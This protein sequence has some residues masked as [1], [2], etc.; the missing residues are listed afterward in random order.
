MIGKKLRIKL[1]LMCISGGAF[2]QQDPMYTQYMFNTLAVNPAYAGSRNVLS[3]TGLYRSQWVGMQGA[4]ETQTLSFD[5]SLPN[6]KVGLGFQVFNDKIGITQT[7]GA[8]ASYAFRIRMEESTLAFGIQGG[9]SNFKANYTSV[10]TNQGTPGGND[11][12]F[13]EDINVYLPNFGAGVYFNTDRF[14][15]GVGV[16]HLLNNVLTKSNSVIVTNG[17]AAR[18]FLH[19]FLTGGFVLD[20]SDDFKLKPSLLVKGVRG[21]PLEVD[22]N[23]NLWIKDVFSVGF[24]YRHKADVAAMFEVQV[25]PQIRIGYSYDR[26]T[27]RL[28]NFNS[29]S[30]EIMLRYEFA[31]EDDRI[32]A[33]RYF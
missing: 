23:S 27:T 11:P 22:A 25:N 33:P 13:R 10:E 19:V 29:G 7:T 28:V 9:V 4:P 8:F 32:L 20:L 5:T 1:L 18:Q 30:H 3:V 31:F 26:N 24:Q 17:L 21:A 6:K 16:P 14:Y 12:A 15:L 2:A